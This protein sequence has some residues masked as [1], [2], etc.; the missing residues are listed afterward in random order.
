[1]SKD[2]P[3][4]KNK[5]G[6]YWVKERPRKEDLEKYYSEKYYQEAKGS[7]EIEYDQAEQ[8]YFVNKIAQKAFVL[9]QHLNVAKP[10]LL[11][12]GCGEGWALRY[13]KKKN[14]DVLGLDYS[15]FG[16]EKFNPECSAN[17]IVG[18]VYENLDKLIAEGRK[19]DVVWIDNV[20]EHVIDPEY[21][22]NNIKNIVSPSGILVVEVP[23]DF[24]VIQDYVLRNEYID[25]QFWVA[26]PDHLSYFN[27][28]GLENLLHS[29]GWKSI[30][31][32]SDYPI[33]WSLLN[34][35]TNYIKDKSK[36]K[37]CHRT[38]IEFENLVHTLPT[39][40][41]INFYKAMADLGLGRSI[42]GFFKLSGQ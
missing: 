40:K 34:P 21:L 19:F 11:D 7:Y 17:M 30:S 3:L 8:D 29:N 10:K 4:V 14:W 13:F 9:D 25:R 31:I 1:M 6:F 27:K 24:S 23:N 39:D 20:L 5:Y 16:C 33:D 35:N 36:G 12:V 41:V 37:S 42:T 2:N 18:N 38:R 32:L 26:I 28:E 15:S 22:I